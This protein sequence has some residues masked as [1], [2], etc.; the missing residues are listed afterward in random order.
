MKQILLLVL[1]F[2]LSSCVNNEYQLSQT[3]LGGNQFNPS[4]SGNGRKIAFTYERN[5]EKKI[6]LKDLA[7]G[8][9][10]PLRHLSRYQPYASPSL[11]WNGRYLAII[12]KVQGRRIAF[13]EDLQSG[14]VYKI[15]L[16]FQALPTNISLAPDATK[17]VIQ[18]DNNGKSFFE[19]IDLRNL[20]TPD[21]YNLID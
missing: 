16:Q 19:F 2:F 21:K 15:P 17:V 12:S 9:I 14:K 20:L 5:G 1:S 3:L 10:L 4:L 8:R 13:I 18:F 11:S 7:N 6:L